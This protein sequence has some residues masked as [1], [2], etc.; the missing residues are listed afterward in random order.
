MWWVDP[1]Q[2][3]RGFRIPLSKVT[4]AIRASNTDVGGSSI[5]MSEREYM[6]RGRGYLSGAK[7]L[8]QI[9]LK[10]TGGT[11][12]FLRDVGHVE[13]G[14]DERRGLTELNGEGEVTS[15][16][17]LQRDGANALSVIKSVKQ[18]DPP[19]SAGSPPKG[20]SILPVYDRS[21]LIYRAIDTLKHT[22]IEESIIIALVCLVFLLH[23]RSA[24][25]AILMLPVGDA[26]RFRRHAAHRAQ[27][28]HHDLGGIA[29]RGHWRNGRDAAIVMI[30]NAHKRLER[31]GP[32]TSRASGSH[33]GMASEVG[34]A[35]F[36]SLLVI[37]ESR[38]LPISVF[39]LEAQEG[40]LFKPLVYTYTGHS[41]CS[42]SCA[43]APS[44]WSSLNRW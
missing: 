31:A 4:D 40:R 39:T 25:V 23:V 21:N 3:L 35:L 36:F 2:R 1:C 22:L 9:V 17:V 19:R 24:L 33:Q 38:S 10:S 30:E 6:V 32:G 27:L 18:K 29:D 15:G 7:D 12:V 13:L 11:P 20:V 41:R 28:E 8:E 42:C 16:I 44:P 5:E 14:P 26:D 37:H 34:P 43:A